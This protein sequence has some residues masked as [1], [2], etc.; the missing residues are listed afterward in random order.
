MAGG[1]VVHGAPAS[2][3][4]AYTFAMEGKTLKQA[5]RTIQQNTGY[6]VFYSDEEVDATAKVSFE[7]RDSSIDKIMNDLLKG[8]GLTFKIKKKHVLVFPAPAPVAEPVEAPAQQEKKVEVTGTVTDENGEGLPGVNVLIK[9]T[10]EG[11]ATD[12]FGKFVL[13][14]SPSAVLRFSSM[15][16]KEKEV[17]VGNQT[18]FD[19][20]LV[21]DVEQLNEIVV[22]GYGTQKKANITGA[23]SS[24]KMSKV[25]GSRPINRV[26][27]ALQGAVPGLQVTTNS[28]Q[29]GSTGQSINIRGMASINGGGSPL[30]L[31][32]NVPVN[33]NDIN[34]N[35]IETVTVLKDASASAIYGARAA[36]GVIVITTKKSSQTDGIKFRYSNSIGFSEAAELP[37]AASPIEFVGALKDWGVGQHWSLGQDITR[38]HE[39]ISEYNSNP[40]SNPDGYVMENGVRY[41][42]RGTDTMDEFLGEGGLKQMHNFSFDGSNGRTNY[43][44]SLG[45]VDDDG[46]MVTNRDRMKQYTLNTFLSTKLRKNLTAEARINYL[47]RH[48]SFPKANYGGAVRAGISIY[49]MGEHTDLD[50]NVL[51]YDDPANQVRYKTPNETKNSNVR[52]FGALKYE[53]VKD[54][55][56]TGEYTYENRNTNNLEVNND[57]VMVG[58]T[59]LSKVGGNPTNTYVKK[60]NSITN[61]SAVNLY[62]NYSKTLFGAHNI[63]L[64]GGYNFEQSSSTNLWSRKNELINPDLPALV[65]ADGTLLSE[66]GGSEWAV[67]G[68]F[69]RLNYNYKERYF[70]SVS[71]RYDGS[72]RFPTEDRFGFFP[73]VSAGWNLANEAFM[74]DQSIV[75]LLKFRG[76]WGTIGNQTTNG[77][78]PYIPTMSTGRVGWLD[79]GERALTIYAP[80]LV[81]ASF[82]WETVETV[83]VGVDFGALDNRLTGSF[84]VYERQTKDMITKPAEKPAVLGAAPPVANAA[85]LKSYGWELTVGWRQTVGDFRYSVNFNLYDNKAEITKYDNPAGLLSDYYVGRENGEIWGFVTDGFYQVSDFVDGTLKDDLT[86]G[87]LK[88][89]VVKYKGRNPN[90]GDIKYKD[91]NGDGEIFVG[92]VTL[93][94]PGDRKI[95]GNSNRRFQYGMNLSAGWKN[96]DVGVIIQGV[97]KRDVWISNDLMWPYI[98]QFDNVWKHQLDY[99]TPENT[100]AEYMRVYPG[101]SAN[102]GNG[103]STQ[104]KYLQ[105][106][107]YWSLKNVTVGYTLPQSIIERLSLSSFRVY[108]SGENMFMDDHLPQGLNPEFANK[109][110]GGA[111]PFM[112]QYTFGLNVSF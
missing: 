51:P 88:E 57:P 86:G 75:N 96:F 71:G 82:T 68:V 61:Y 77:V 112:K 13:S 99:W 33:I 108:F 72:S 37:E 48:T 60:T 45:F 101:Q 10:T 22:V 5:F 26:A 49:P 56:I 29:P 2:D 65:L 102:Y 32:D 63:S 90:P 81:S 94:D 19:I 47:N 40:G 9:G 53:P 103:R 91:L 35:D 28:G 20:A 89:G 95:I 14:V 69:G 31:V 52:L 98:Q 104:T 50:G 38:W 97:G 92:D 6:K 74:Q 18:V 109:G 7:F 83:N 55:L 80:P 3:S 23:V 25:L 42:L 62:G 24:V 85:N 58:R 8:T 110:R 73:S 44:A 105:D 100:D 46:I 27:E 1:F 15:G 79:G 43:R 84:E 17:T 70:L 107:S 106:G 16:F 59:T 67:M 64:T 54:L 66:D 21:P 36:F 4:E 87:T 41:Q 11:T 39:L 93:E 111:Y 30:I 34:A 12:V 78:Y 76:A